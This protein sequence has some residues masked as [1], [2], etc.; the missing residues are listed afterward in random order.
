MPNRHVMSRR[1]ENFTSVEHGGQTCSGVIYHAAEGKHCATVILMHGLGDSSDGMASL[2]DVFYIAFPWVKF[3]L[4]TATTRPVT[5][6][7]GHTMTA[8]YDIVGL[9]K[10]SNEHCD[11]I[12]VSVA[13]IRKLLEEEHATGLPYSRIALAGFSQGAALSLYTGLQMDEDKK[14]S[15]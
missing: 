7:M 11:G 5:M 12:D 1:I 8:W 3:I 14:V 15:N 2:A 6:N 9:D 13:R 10:R 4:P